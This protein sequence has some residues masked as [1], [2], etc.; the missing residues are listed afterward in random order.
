VKMIFIFLIVLFLFLIPI[1][2]HSQECHS[3]FNCKYGQRC[4]KAP[5]KMRGV[6]MD[7]VDD[8][9]LK[10]FPPPDTDSMMPK[11]EGDCQFNTDC[12]I[13]FYCHPYYKVCVKRR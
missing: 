2:A 4:V 8:F 9:G 3:D 10:Q 13:G 5:F 1:L 6:C 7:A 12:P 11:V